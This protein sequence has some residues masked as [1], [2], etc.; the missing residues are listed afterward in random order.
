MC[1]L[2]LLNFFNVCIIYIIL[3]GNNA[4]KGETKKILKVER[5]A[6]LSFAATESIKL[7]QT[8]S[9]TSGHAMAASGTAVTVLTP[10]GRR[11]TVKVA[12]N[13]PLLQVNFYRGVFHLYL[14]GRLIE[15]RALVTESD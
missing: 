1:G 9:V 5:T 11:Q 2:F 3:L 7:I 14:G 12:P 10:N 4:H 15:F 6:P 13:T 8:N